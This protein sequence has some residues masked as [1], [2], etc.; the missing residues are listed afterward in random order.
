MA[1]HGIKASILFSPPGT[2]QYITVN[3]TTGWTADSDLQMLAVGPR[4]GDEWQEQ[5]PSV[6]NWGGSI[7]VALNSDGNQTTLINTYLNA[8]VALASVQ[9]RT[10]GQGTVHG[11]I[12][13]NGLN[14]GAPAG[15]LQ[16]A[17]FSFISAG[18]AGMNFT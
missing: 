16:V 4:H 7:D 11:L 13:L 2:T 1:L 6:R 12:R 3:E 8:T 9:L 10:G 18:T 17:T 5:L 15:D 14:M